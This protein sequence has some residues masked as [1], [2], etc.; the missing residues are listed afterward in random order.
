LFSYADWGSRVARKADQALRVGAT[1]P[2]LE[3]LATSGVTLSVT[4]G[5]PLFDDTA[6]G[7]DDE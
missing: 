6:H 1:E 5:F 4:T 7:S 2:N 3:A